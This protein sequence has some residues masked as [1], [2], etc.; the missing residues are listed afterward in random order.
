MIVSKTKVIMENENLLVQIII[1]FRRYIEH[2]ADC[3]ARIE[4]QTRDRVLN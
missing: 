1:G 3:C 4:T 2:H